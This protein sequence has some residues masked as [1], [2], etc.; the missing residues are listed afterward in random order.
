MAVAK[1][2]RNED[3]P[4]D[5]SRIEELLETELG[6]R[7]AAPSHP[8]GKRDTVLSASPEAILTVGAV[9]CAGAVWL[10]RSLPY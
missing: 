4:V 10:L 9:A 6:G 5:L 3:F 8:S 1:T 7:D 2:E